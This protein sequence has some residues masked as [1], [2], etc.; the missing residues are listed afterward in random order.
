MP[1]PFSGGC[2]CGAVRYECSA[3]PL[4]VTNCHCRDC[5]R[6]SGSAFASVLLVPKAAFTLTK[7]TPK[8]HRVTADSGN[9]VDRG[10]CPECGSPVLVTVLQNPQFTEIQAA[11][12]DDPSWVQ[13]RIDMFTA[14]A[15][16]WDPMNP[17]LPKW[18]T[19]PTQEQWQELITGHAK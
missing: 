14:R 7:G 9:L 6:A 13:P 3:D 12:L 19:Q 5:Q 17:A 8:Y 1:T 15:Q 10:F 4:F 2:A 18:G 16:P 11:S